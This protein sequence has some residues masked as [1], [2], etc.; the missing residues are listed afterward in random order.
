MSEMGISRLARMGGYL[1]FTV[2]AFAVGAGIAMGLGFG[3]RPR[4]LGYLI[5]L[6]G[7]VATVLTFERWW[8]AVR[9]LVGMG[10]LNG[11]SALYSGHTLTQPNV[12]VSRLAMTFLVVVLVAANLV[13]L[14]ATPVDRG[15]AV[16]A[17]Y[18]GM[19][20]CVVTMFTCAIMSVEGWETPV[21]V[22]FLGCLA[23]L[24]LRWRPAG[25]VQR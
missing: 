18:L 8:H 23:L 21:A 17:A 6:L 2:L 19:F 22:V 13:L 9:V 3:E 11:L 15:F 1:L 16:R 4:L 24:W 20:G 12:Q 14:K 25:H 10:I 7:L 5:A